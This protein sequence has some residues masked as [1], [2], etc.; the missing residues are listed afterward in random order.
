MEYF[1]ALD[2]E[3]ILREHNSLADEISVAA[4]TL[5]LSDGL[6]KYKI[7]ME[8]ILDLLFQITE[9]IGKFLMMRN[10]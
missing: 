10:E 3:A 1:D 8:V 5:Q 9:I 4:S 6:I 7:K 2:L